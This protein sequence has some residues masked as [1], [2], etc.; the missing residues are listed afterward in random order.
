MRCIRKNKKYGFT[1]I[2]LLITTVLAAVI[3]LT[4]Y[5]ALSQAVKIWQRL[6][7]RIYE[8]DINIFFEKFS[9]DLR[10]SFKFSAIKFAGTNDE[11]G[12]ATLVNS[13]SKLP[14]LKTNVGEVIYSF[15]RQEGVINRRQKNLSQIYREEEGYSAAA[16]KDVKSF[17]L[18]YYFYDPRENGYLW[19]EEWRGDDLPRAVRIEL[20]LDDGTQI[21]KFIKTVSLPVSGWLK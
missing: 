14:G 15:N 9:R 7:Q 17:K 18:Q 20:E 12:F 5:T 4:L 1:F 16:L 2:E 11:F 6:N 10:N 13:P 3:A 21:N 8:E 19:Q